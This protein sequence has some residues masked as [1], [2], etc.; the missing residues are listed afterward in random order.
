MGGSGFAFSRVHW[1][2]EVFMTAEGSFKVFLVFA[3]PRV[4]GVVVVETV[5]GG[6]RWCCFE[7]LCCSARE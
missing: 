7:S 5:E 3:S 2:M 6:I 4:V 1:A